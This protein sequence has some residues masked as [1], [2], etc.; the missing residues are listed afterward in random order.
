[1][2]YITLEQLTD[3][4]G[5]EALIAL[6]DR[7]TPATG[8]LDVDVIN[9]AIAD[10]DALIDGYL[11]AR[12]ALPLAS[13]PPLLTDIA[14]AIAF[15]NLHTFQPDQKVETDYKTAQARLKDIAAGTIRLPLG[16]GSE[17]QASG[18]TG[19]RVTDRDR[20]MTADKMKGFI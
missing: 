11:G 1:M 10:A 16:D 18:E 5:A 20:P 3:R 19:A 6:T 17:A 13:T 15:W 7:A 2:A 8:V 14:A 12:Y 4:Y 9:R